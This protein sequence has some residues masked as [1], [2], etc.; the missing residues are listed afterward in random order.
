MSSTTRAVARPLAASRS[1]TVDQDRPVLGG[2]RSAA[3]AFVTIG[4]QVD[5]RD[6]FGAGDELHEQRGARALMLD[7]QHGDEEDAD[8][9]HLRGD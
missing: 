3:G 8:V 5:S 1:R 7:L 4:T 6:G 9:R 2:L